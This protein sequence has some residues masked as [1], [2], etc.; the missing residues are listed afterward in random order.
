M[1]FYD[2]PD[3]SELKWQFILNLKWSERMCS[4]YIQFDMK[5]D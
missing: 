1:E 2:K 4:Q 3:D 5:F